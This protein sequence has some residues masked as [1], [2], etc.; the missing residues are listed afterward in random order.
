MLLCILESSASFI[1]AAEEKAP[2]FICDN[3]YKIASAFSKFYHD[4]RIIDEADETKRNSWL[5]LC[6]LT[7]R[8]IHLHLDILAIEP[9]ENM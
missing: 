2:N 5:A 1:A 8:L 7:K 9:V 4:N 6:L 3:A